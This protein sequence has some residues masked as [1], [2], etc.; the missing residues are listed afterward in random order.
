MD[1]SAGGRLARAALPIVALLSFALGL[2]ATLAVAGNTL[3]FD[4]AF[5]F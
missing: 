4:F 5:L 1:A 3:G 2:A